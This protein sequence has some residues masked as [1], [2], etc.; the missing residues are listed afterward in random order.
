MIAFDCGYDT[1]FDAA[2]EPGE[3]LATHWNLG[4]PLNPFLRFGG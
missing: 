2:P 4:S 1:Y 3:Y